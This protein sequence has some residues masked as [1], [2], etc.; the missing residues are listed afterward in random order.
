MIGTPSRRQLWQGFRTRA[1]LRGQAHMIIEVPYG[2][3]GHQQLTVPD[4]NYLG[5]L[6]PNE[7]P[8]SDEQRE[9]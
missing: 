2:K 1:S 4:A 3:D 6:R 8:H 9:L 7:L 5:T